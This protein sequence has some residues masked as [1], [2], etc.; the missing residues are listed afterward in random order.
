MSLGHVSAFSSSVRRR[1]RT[2]VSWCSNETLAL[3][4][5]MRL[6]VHAGC[7]SWPKLEPTTHQPPSPSGTQASGDS[8]GRPDFTPV[9][10]ST[11][12]GTIIRLTITRPP[13]S[14]WRVRSSG[15][16]TLGPT[17]RNHELVAILRVSFPTGPSTSNAG[18]G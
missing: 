13:V 3:G 8:R 11:I 4:S 5:A 15:G 9:V 16:T 17:L 1:E 10:V 12:D 14:L 7:F 2:G 18:M 6:P